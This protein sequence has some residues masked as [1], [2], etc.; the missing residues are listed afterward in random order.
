MFPIANQF[1]TAVLYG[2]AGRL[3]AKTGGLRP[4]QI[5]PAHRLSTAQTLTSRLLVNTAGSVQL[6]H[7]SPMAFDFECYQQVIPQY[8][9]YKRGCTVYCVL[10]VLCIVCAVYCA[11]CAVYGMVHLL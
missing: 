2:C 9:I 10:S 5:N 4:G 8:T 7:G 11:P 1:C 6:D 3:T